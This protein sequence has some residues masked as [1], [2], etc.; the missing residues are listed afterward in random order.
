MAVAGLLAGCGGYSD[1]FKQGFMEECLAGS[2]GQR[3]Y[4]QC[5]LEHLEAN[6]PSNEKELTS[7]DQARA[8]EACQGQIAG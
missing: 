5:V 3:Q 8:I 1:E 7:R 2:G 4:C 6:G